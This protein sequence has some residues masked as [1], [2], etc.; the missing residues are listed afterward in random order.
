MNT[1]LLRVVV[2]AI[3]LATLL[4]TGYGLRR[5]GKPYGSILLSAHK[6]V[7]VAGLAY[8]IWSAIAASKVAA[9]TSVAWSLTSLTALSLV[10]LIGTGGVLSALASPPRAIRWLHKVVPYVSILL[11][12]LWLFAD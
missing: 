12:G 7:S 11:A 10:I 2:V 6:L 5:R 1:G 9:L 3:G 8:V 4:G